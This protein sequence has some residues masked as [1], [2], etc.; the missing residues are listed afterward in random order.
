MNFFLAID[1]DGVNHL[2]TKDGKIRLPVTPKE[3]SDIN[4]SKFHN[5]QVGT[6]I[7]SGRTLDTVMNTSLGTPKRG[8]RK[9]QKILKMLIELMDKKY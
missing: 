8:G 2:A 7:D 3:A 4:E 5:K 6:P 9:D 1:R